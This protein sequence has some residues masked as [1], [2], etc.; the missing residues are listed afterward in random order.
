V[1]VKFIY[2]RVSD[3]G[4]PKKYLLALGD[5][6]SGVAAKN[7]ESKDDEGLF[8]KVEVA[9]YCNSRCV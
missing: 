4:V 2:E 9:N 1:S 3:S 8:K 7:R 5:F 6:L